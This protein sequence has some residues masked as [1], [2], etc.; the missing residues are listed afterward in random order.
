MKLVKV[1]FISFGGFLIVYIG[2]GLAGKMQNQKEGE[3]RIV[4]DEMPST[5]S[6]EKSIPKP[7]GCGIAGR[8]QRLEASPERS[9]ASLNV[10]CD[11]DKLKFS[12][13]ATFSP[14][15]NSNAPRV[16]WLEGVASPISADTYSFREVSPY[17]SSS[18]DVQIKSRV[19]NEGILEVAVSRGCAE[20]GGLG[21]AFDGDFLREK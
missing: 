21:V 9:S 10:T 19:V 5:I 16:G 2:G 4:V 15:S 20:Y 12:L 3:R 11:G 6:V 7:D 13:S 18:C 17:A 8:W 14:Y 1:F